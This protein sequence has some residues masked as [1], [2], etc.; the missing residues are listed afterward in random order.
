MFRPYLSLAV[1]LGL[2]AATIDAQT[3]QK[4]Q[5]KEQ[6]RLAACAVVMNE[7]LDVPDNVPQDRRPLRPGHHHEQSLSKRLSLCR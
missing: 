4:D 7:V 5:N 1:C 3:T 6:E 2:A